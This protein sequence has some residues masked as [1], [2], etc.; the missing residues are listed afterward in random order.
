[1]EKHLIYVADPM[2][3]WCWGFSPVVE[4]IRE[5]FGEELSFLMVMGGLRPGTSDAMDDSGK[6][7]IREH[8]GHVLER[9]GQPF[10]FAFF[11]REG[12][13][14]DTEPPSRAVVSA[15]HTSMDA[16]FGLMKRIQKAFYAENR[17]VTDGEILCDL[18]VEGGIDRVA[19]K[20]LFDSDILREET[21][22]DFISARG[23]GI[24]G[25]P[26]L[27]A[28]SESEGYEVIT[29]GYRP[30]DEVK[31]LIESWLADEGG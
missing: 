13:V 10:D 3:S 20:D 27:I 7:M 31:G 1:M 21:Q 25:F 23:A 4:S 2:C 15:R 19:F 6:K 22:N 11:D 28:G 17:D 30:W 5:K 26:A 8:W 24:N 29:I 12:F 14:Y 9:T 18:A 16:A